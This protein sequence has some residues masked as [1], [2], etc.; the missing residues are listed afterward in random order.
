MPADAA[1]LSTFKASFKT[2]IAATLDGVDADK[3]I[4]T[5]VVSGS[6]VVDFY[7]AP[8]A[9]GAALVAADAVTTALAAGV[10]V[11]GATLTAESVSTTPTVTPAPAPPP[12]APAPPPA[13][14]APAPA[15]SGATSAT[16]TAGVALA[17]FAFVQ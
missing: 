5:G 9:D 7:I 13:A 4:I 2:D 14:P 3:V 6:V 1:A 11:A 8:A 16:L 15:T 12:A 10:S 17:V